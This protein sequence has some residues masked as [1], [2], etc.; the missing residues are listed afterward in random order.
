VSEFAI[1]SAKESDHALM[2]RIAAGDR[3]ALEALY[4]RYHRRLARFLG[5]FTPRYENVEEVINDTFLIVW[6]SAAGFRHASQ[7]STWIF[8]IAYRTVLKSVRRQKR[9]HGAVAP[10]THRELSRDPSDAAETR[11]WIARALDELPLDQRMALELAYHLGYSLEE[12][13]AITG[14]PVGTIK[15]RMFH[16]R[17]TLKRYLPV[18]GGM[19]EIG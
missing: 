2:L 5:R 14:A 13:A 11:D 9:H 16:A 18:L 1:N 7:V 10:D 3:R 17:Q 6:Q 8:G 15:A 4:L 12:I 19:A